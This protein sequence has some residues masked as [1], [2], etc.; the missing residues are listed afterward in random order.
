MMFHQ[1][2]AGSGVLEVPGLADF[3]AGRSCAVGFFPAVRRRKTIMKDLARVIAAV[4]LVA[5]AVPAHAAAPVV[6]SVYPASQRI[7]AGASTAIEVHFDQNVDL[8]SVTPATFRVSGRWSG[9]ASGN[10]TVSGSTITFTPSKPF[11]AGEWITA[12]VTKGVTNTSAEHLATGYTWNFWIETANG[13]LTLTFDYRINCRVSPET[14]V[15]VYGAYGGDLNKDGFSDLTAPCEQTDDA[16]V[17]LS[18]NGLFTAPPTKVS[19]VNGAIPSPNEGADFDND[20]N[21][22]LVI[23][24]TGGSNASILFGNGLGG[25]P[26]A[27][28]T[29]VLCGNTIR[30]VGVA[31]FNGDGWDDFVTANRFANSNHGNLSI[32]LNNGDGTFAAAV[33]KETGKE[34]E[35]TIAIA[36][37]NNDGIPDIFCGC[38]LT[39]YW[40]VILLG[41]GN[42]GFTVSTSVAEGGSP[43]QT[44]VGDFNGDGNVDVAS[45]NSNT[46]N[47]GL[48][49]GNGAG[50]FSGSVTL[51]AC[52]SFPLAIDAGDIDG[53]GDLEL[54][55]SCYTAAKWDVFT[56]TAGVF[57]NKKTLAASSA[58]SC[59]V[60]H[61]RDNDG[62][63]DLSGLDEVDDWIYFWENTGT[64]TNVPP[65]ALPATALLQNHPNP[66]N[67]ST[68]IRFELHHDAN[69]TLSVYDAAGAYVTTLAAGPYAHGTHDVTWNGTDAKGTRVGSGVYFYRLD[70][71][72]QTLTRKMVLLK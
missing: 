59:C 47:I 69:V 41:D 17:F 35:Y 23:G 7:D 56:N 64:A 70:A 1:L 11:F 54:V 66:F 8:A 52:D 6:T 39:P 29:S 18:N 14:W 28:K 12:S 5:A 62:D 46:N 72:G 9:P 43:W 22:D 71:P 16:R 55:T 34:Q 48:L 44:V 45:C 21:I 49:L 30:G 57:G 2:L 25:F 61:D 26:T 58:G 42:G 50:G 36:D 63:L 20:G 33:T 13:S 37:A 24:N 53:D 15:Q 60:L 27:R 3:G 65:P 10:L 67:P 32:V 68:S 38:F 31:D 40:M 4:L 51:I 19:L